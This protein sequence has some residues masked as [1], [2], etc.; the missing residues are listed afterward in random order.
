VLVG[1]AGTAAA[2]L[3]TIHDGSRRRKGSMPIPR[4]SA[5]LLVAAPLVLTVGLSAC[6]DTGAAPSAPDRAGATVTV[7]TF[8]FAPDPLVVSVGTVITFVNEDPIDHTVTAGTREAPEPE[9]FDG[10]LARKGSTFELTLDEPGSY[11]YF[12]QIHPG[13]GMTATITV[14][15]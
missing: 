1:Q 10:Q 4:R 12:C 7:A 5:L 6:G 3:G 8:S 2:R 11:D 14:E 9:H 15:P 13:P